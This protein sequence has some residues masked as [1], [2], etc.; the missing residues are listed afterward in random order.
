MLAF[1]PAPLAHALRSN[2][3]RDRRIRAPARRLPSCPP[4]AE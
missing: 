4:P 3:A 2:Q 1:H